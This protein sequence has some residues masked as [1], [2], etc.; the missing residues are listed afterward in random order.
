MKD[1]IRL[2]VFNMTAYDAVAYIDTDISIVGDV[3]PL[4]D[5]AATGEFMM[6]QGLHAPLNAGV[7]ALRPNEE[8]FKLSLWFGARASFSQHPQDMSATTGGWDGGGTYP[9]EN[10]WPVNQFIVPLATK[11][12]LENLLRFRY[13]DVRALLTTSSLS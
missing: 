10:G 12:L 11:N 2:H 8:L 6:T 4:L 3:M 13:A 1:L 5:C 9:N 7:M